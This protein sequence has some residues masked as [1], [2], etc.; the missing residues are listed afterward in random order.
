V[1]NF[2]F[3]C[4][5]PVQ[6]ASAPPPRVRAELRAY[7][8]Q[9]LIDKIL[10]SRATLQ[11]ERKQVTVLFADVKGSM[12]LAEQ[13]DPEE[14]HRIMDR[15]FAILTDGVHRFE[16]TVNQ[17]TG[18]GIMALFGAPIAHEDHA[19]RACHAALVLRDALRGYA[20]QLRR[21]RGLDFAVRIGLNSGAV[22][23]GRIGDDLRMDYTAQGHTVGLA[24]R[25]EQLAEAGGVYVTEHTAALAAGFFR[26]DDL[27]LFT[28]KGVREPLRVHALQGT[29]ELRT[30]F[31][32]SRARG[33]SRFVGRTA[34]S[35]LLEEALGDAARSAAPIVAI[36]AE[37][38]TGKSR[39]CFEFLN[40]CRERG[41]HVVDAHALAHARRLPF[42]PV[43]ELIRQL[44]GIAADDA[45]QVGRE[46]I[47]GRLLLLDPELRELLPLVFEFLGIASGETAPLPVDADVR[48]QRLI[49]MIRRVVVAVDAPMVLLWEDLHWLDEASE[50]FLRELLAALNETRALLLLSC[51]PEYDCGWLPAARTRRLLLPPLDGDSTGALLRDLLGADPALD[52]LAARIRDRTGGNPFFIEEVVNDLAEHGALG[53]GRGAYRLLEAVQ[54]LAIPSAVETLLAGRLDRLGETGKAVL[55]TAAVI[56]RQFGA[57]LLQ[58]ASAIPARELR[59]LLRVLVDADFIYAEPVEGAQYAFKHALTQEVAER[60]QLAAQR[61]A[62]HAAV[63]QAME[64]LAPERLDERAALLAHHWEGA[65]DRIAAAR[66]YGRAAE[67]LV[68]SDPRQAL[69]DWRR[70]YTLLGEEPAAPERD[71]W[72]VTACTRLMEISAVMA[73]RTENPHVLY[74]Q[75]RGLA[76]RLAD[77]GLTA[78]LVG[79]Y[80]T[81]LALSGEVNE[82]LALSEQATR[83]AESS[84]DPAARVDV[85]Y[86]AVFLYDWRGD[87]ARQLV[88]SDRALAL[89]DAH[90][91]LGQRGRRGR[92]LVTKGAAL[93]NIGRMGEAAQALRDAERLGEQTGDL[94]LRGLAASESAWL[95]YVRGDPEG[96]LVEA[97]RAVRCGQ[98]IGSGAIV[99]PTVTVMGALHGALGQW[100]TSV[101]MLELVAALV[102]DGRRTFEPIVLAFLAEAYLGSGDPLRARTTAEAAVAAAQRRGTRGFEARARMAHARI[103]LRYEGAAAA[104]Q[105]AVLWAEIDALIEETDARAFAPYLALDRAELAAQLGDQQTREKELRNARTMFAEMDCPPMIAKID[106]L[107]Q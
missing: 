32:L 46:K 91:E 59:A 97:E 78:R 9:H 10:T 72:L 85:A 36:V 82:A 7:T 14:W 70:A 92:L 75:A 44:F 56:G 93:G 52:E 98:Q 104:P 81:A 48:Q 88:V 86:S 62:R 25:M 102:R 84:G 68:R 24:S 26:L 11:G 30:R 99:G 3:A 49:E 95:E 34:E 29:G 45:A 4:G 66:W 40:G 73:Q 96:A 89:I 54:T 53:G 33:L 94:E 16:G 107:L 77:P 5:R 39:L 43:R 38:G 41:V 47:A 55:Q 71:R 17:F 19:Q 35:A 90:P 83:L 2:C 65:G 63:A 50:G 64:A 61:A 31:D 37:P 106:R 57:T 42:L 23:V 15:F 6:N 1:A 18:D 20:H 76:D 13:L 51:R 58:R 69:A 105:L 74:D 67:W 60:S 12:E 27:G 80:A 101:S 8:P 100:T 22:V 87:Y 21:E 103:L 79:N 28:V